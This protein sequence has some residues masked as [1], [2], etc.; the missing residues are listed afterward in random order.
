MYRLSVV[1]CDDDSF[2]LQQLRNKHYTQ[3]K[4]YKMVQCWA[5]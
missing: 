1:H 2:E 5:S 4:L 3:S